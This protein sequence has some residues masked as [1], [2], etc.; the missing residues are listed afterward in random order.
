MPSAVVSAVSI[1]VVT[2]VLLAS[3]AEPTTGAS[4]REDAAL[5]RGRP[6][7]LA[8]HGT[9]GRS[10]PRTD[11]LKITGKVDALVAEKNGLEADINALKLELGAR[12]DVISELK[13]E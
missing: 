4:A 5:L 3:A 7:V 9:S 10:L 2:A 1:F 8:E 6:E 11:D 12:D 13:S